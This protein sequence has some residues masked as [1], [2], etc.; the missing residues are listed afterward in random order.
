M[1]TGFIAVISIYHVTRLLFN[2]RTALFALFF[3]AVNF[4]LIRYSQ[5]VRSYS[6]LILLANYSFY[7]FT[8]IVREGF[9]KKRARN[10]IIVT[11]FMLYTHYFSLFVIGAQFFAF[12]FLVDWSEIR[13]NLKS[14]LITFALPNLLFLFWVP[15]ILDGLKKERGAWR[16]EA[17][18]SLV[19]EYARDFFNDTYLAII[20]IVVLFVTLLY[21][22]LRKHYNLE[23][24]QKQLKPD[25]VALIVLLTWIIVYFMLPYL[26]SSLSSTMMFNRYF[27]P[28]VPPVLILMSFY[29]SKIN[30]ALLR[31]G[32][33]LALVGYSVYILFSH[34]N[35]YYTQTHMYREATKELKETSPNAYV[36]Q[37]GKIWFYFDYYLRQNDFENI[38]EGYDVNGRNAH[39]EK[40]IEKDNP[41]EYYGLLNLRPLLNQ[42]KDSTIAP[43][44]GYK[45]VESKIYK[46]SY[47]RECTKVIKYIKVKD[48]IIT[49]IEP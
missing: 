10:Y 39:F 47:G 34:K 29:I 28:L 2:K 17:Q 44:K 26:K 16:D 35:P 45:E 5:E 37:H 46:N 19:Y 9:R 30:G 23:K 48:T 12:L 49:Q 7:F 42:F 8:Q 36:L 38:S 33:F 32:V 24:I 14:Y 20:A 25:H 13:K 18:L 4:Y 40:L 11:T 31:N 6:L 1:I 15:N 21:F 3:A 43:I 41:E 27:I 22:L